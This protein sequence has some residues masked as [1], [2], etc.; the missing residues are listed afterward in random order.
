MNSFFS[1]YG[2]KTAIIAFF[3]FLGKGILW[4]LVVYFGFEIFFE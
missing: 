2:R 3:F 4:L 1:K